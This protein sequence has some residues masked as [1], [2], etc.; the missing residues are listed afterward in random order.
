MKLWNEV[1]TFKGEEKL[2]SY[3]VYMYT[4]K[5]EEKLWS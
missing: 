3:E 2:W 5:V 1:Y 4:F